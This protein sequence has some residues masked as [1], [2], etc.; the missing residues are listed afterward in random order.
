MPKKVWRIRPAT[1][2]DASDLKSCMES[3]YAV[4]QDRLSGTRLPPMRSEGVV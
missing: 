2:E 4:Y 3:A 1:V